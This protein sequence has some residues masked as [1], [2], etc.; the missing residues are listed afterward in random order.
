MHRLMWKIGTAQ[1]RSIDVPIGF[2]VLVC[3]AKPKHVIELRRNANIDLRLYR[4]CTEV[5]VAHIV[6]ASVLYPLGTQLHCLPWLYR[7]LWRLC[8]HRGR[9]SDWRPTL[10]RFTAFRLDRAFDY[11]RLP[12]A[13]APFVYVRVIAALLWVCRYVFESALNYRDYFYRFLGT[14]R[15]GRL[16]TVSAV[17][18][19]WMSWNSS[20]WNTT[21]PGVIA[22]FRSVSG[23]R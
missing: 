13:E 8:A 19:Y 11:F 16:K 5:V 21:L 1:C 12:L 2:D 14:I 22:R 18:A 17:A 20:V 7:D 6:G 23:Q 15:S 10:E 9:V 4:R 3:G